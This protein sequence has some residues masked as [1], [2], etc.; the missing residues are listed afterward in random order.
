MVNMLP[1]EAI[2]EFKAIYKKEFGE[3]IS[4]SEAYEKGLRLIQLI[5]AVY[6]PMPE[7]QEDD[8][9]KSEKISGQKRK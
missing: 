1:K 7:I 2:D 9:K 5:K 4:D 8:S 6:S 3:E